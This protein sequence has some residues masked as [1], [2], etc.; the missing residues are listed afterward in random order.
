MAQWFRQHHRHGWATCPITENGVVRI[1][2]QPSYPSGR[3]TPPE[4]IEV[5]TAL[6]FAFKG[7]YEFWDDNVSLV[8][9]AIFDTTLISGS[10]QVTDAYLL[11]LA[12]KRSATLV[13]FDRSLPWQ[14]IKGGTR[15]LIHLPA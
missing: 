14:A 2:S 10:R 7:S 15:K 8:D 1:L 13:S 12:S 5:L 3:R 9:T 11:G 6:K 4:V